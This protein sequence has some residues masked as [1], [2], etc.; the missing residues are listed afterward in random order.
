MNNKKK[1]LITTFIFLLVGISFVSATDVD[2]NKDTTLLT[3]NELSNDAN[4]EQTNNNDMSQSTQANENTIGS[5]N[6]PMDSAILGTSSIYEETDT[7]DEENTNYSGDADETSL[8]PV[9][10][11]S[12]EVFYENAIPDLLNVETTQGTSSSND[13]IYIGTN[14]SMEV[15]VGEVG[16]P[17]TLTAKVGYYDMEKLYPLNY[18]HVYFIIGDNMVVTDENGNTLYVPVKDGVASV[19]TIA[20]NYWITS[21]NRNIKAKYPS[22]QKSEDYTYLTSESNY[23]ELRVYEK[24]YNTTVSMEPVRGGIGDNL[25]FNVTVDIED[26][27]VDSPVNDGYVTFSINDNYNITDSNTGEPLKAE[28]INGKAIINITA[29]INW[30]FI[31][32][33]YIRAIYNGESNYL[34]S[35]SDEVTLELFGES[36][37]SNILNTNTQTKTAANKVINKY[38]SFTKLTKNSDKKFKVIVNNNIIHNGNVM[39][40]ETL[41]KIFDTSFTNGLLIVY[42]DGKLV[43]NGTTTDNLS[44]VILELIEGLTGQHELKV[45]FTDSNKETKSYIENITIK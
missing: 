10:Y 3:D 36:F 2:D 25:T 6:Y 29:D 20:S 19:D 9:I 14:T 15:P 41:N 17:I 31:N 21:A 1:F 27:Q 5:N 12:Q 26:Q 22:Y 18:G 45:E 42:L 8:N 4:P 35:T 33:D 7:D 16:K 38:K 32:H 39:T 23:V 40:L 28:V 24:L 30:L 11:D 43:F 44:Q 37:G 34:D 13:M